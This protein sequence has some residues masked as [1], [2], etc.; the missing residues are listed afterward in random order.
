MQPKVGD[1]LCFAQAREAIEGKMRG[2]GAV[3]AQKNARHLVVSGRFFSVSRKCAL[4]RAMFLLSFFAVVPNVVAE[5]LFCGVLSGGSRS[6]TSIGDVEHDMLRVKN[7]ILYLR[8][9]ILFH[10]LRCVCAYFW[11]NFL[12]FLT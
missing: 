4:V 5:L 8:C 11:M 10:I 9:R 1:F 3:G 7:D 6:S 2:A 12:P